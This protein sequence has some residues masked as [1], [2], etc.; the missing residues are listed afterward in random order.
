M[1][2]NGKGGDLITV[3]FACHYVPKGLERKEKT[4]Y[5]W[6]QLKYNGESNPTMNCLAVNSSL[7]TAGG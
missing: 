2:D 5:H 6:F 7:Q 1:V 4:S 3:R